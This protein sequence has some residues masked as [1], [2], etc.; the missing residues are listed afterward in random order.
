MF[1]V[2]IS[3]PDVNAE[4]CKRLVYPRHTF[5]REY[6]WPTNTFLRHYRSHLNDMISKP[7][8][9]SRNFRWRRKIPEVPSLHSSKRGMCTC[10]GEHS[11]SEE[12]T[13]SYSTQFNVVINK[14]IMHLETVLGALDHFSCELIG[15][16]QLKGAS[17]IVI[18][19]CWFTA[20]GNAKLESLP[21][22]FLLAVHSWSFLWMQFLVQW[23]KVWRLSYFSP[24]RFLKQWQYFLHR[25]TKK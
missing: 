14:M 7:Y 6:K 22:H 5:F 11:R 10:W 23:K 20:T 4:V 18:D 13:V 21:T 17:E 2:H 16:G 3:L 9:R 25:S 24:W 12:D 15:L 19:D 1:S 8:W